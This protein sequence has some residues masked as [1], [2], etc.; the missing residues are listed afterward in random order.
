MIEP[1]LGHQLGHLLARVGGKAHVAVGENADQL[2]GP[3]V[4][5]ALDH[6]NAGNAVV[7]HQL[8]RVGER[9][10]GIDG[11]RVHHHAGF[12]LLDLADLRGLL[13]RLEIAVDDAEAAGL[14]HGDRHLGLG[15]GVHGRGD[16]RDIERDFAS[17]PGADIG[18]GRQQLGQSRLEQDVVEGER[19]AQGSVGFLVH[20]QLQSPGLRA[21]SPGTV[22]SG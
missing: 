10:R 5:A 14:R 7:L 13:V 21:W 22:G 18:V 3:A 11:D 4:A 15:H 1:L 6:R 2:A 16:D 20:R 12:E 17:D 9:G 8:E 19:F